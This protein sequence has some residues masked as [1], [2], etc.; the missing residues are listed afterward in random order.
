MSELNDDAQ[1]VLELVRDAHA[2]GEADRGRVRAELAAR[3]GAAAGLGLAAG[4]G[5]TMKTTAAAGTGGPIAAGAVGAGALTAK[6]VGAALIVSATVGV[7]VTVVHHRRQASVAR[8]PAVEK[9]VRAEPARRPVADVAATVAAPVPAREPAPSMLSLP[10]HTARPLARVALAKAKAV[11][12]AATRPAP[13]ADRP[14]PGAAAAAEKVKPLAARPAVDDEVKLVHDGLVAR[15]AGQ[16]ARA[17]ELLDRHASLYPHG[18]LAE[19][20]D[21]ERALAL[22]DLGRVA[23]ARAAIE[24]FLRA[25][26]GSPL[27]ARLRE[28]ARQLD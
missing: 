12:V 19:E 7:G 9:V 24:A 18:V 6:L 3:I 2:P 25:H 26:P 10:P 20:R 1:L 17:L 5:A 22:A 8:G 21:A 15:R 14:A 23:E 28:R 11:P 13:P 4:L 27:A 16:P